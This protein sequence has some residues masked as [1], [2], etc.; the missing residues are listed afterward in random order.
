M[1]SINIL[2]FLVFGIPAVAY[3]GFT[4]TPESSEI[5]QE[6]AASEPTNTTAE[7]AKPTEA[8]EVQAALNAAAAKT[9]EPAQ[10]PI[11]QPVKSEIPPVMAV[12]PV[13]A[14]KPVAPKPSFFE[15]APVQSFAFNELTISNGS[16]RMQ[17]ERYCQI[18]G[19]QLAWRHPEDLTVTNTTTFKGI[20]FA[21]N[22]KQLF[23]TLHSIG[24]TDMTA[25][26]FDGNKTLV[27]DMSKR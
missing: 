1:R 2:I 23:E 7:P 20:G 10:A 25:T 21:D 4:F 19:Y 15:P 26:I 27:V 9:K 8:P 24:R 22:I 3:G 13:V 5:P 17:I 16:L 14:E 12:T 18:N 6:S 11:A